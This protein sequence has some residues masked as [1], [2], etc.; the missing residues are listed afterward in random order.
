MREVDSKKKR[1]EREDS[2]SKGRLLEWMRAYGISERTREIR[3]VEEHIERMGG[4]REERERMK[5]TFKFTFRKTTPQ[6]REQAERI[7]MIGE[8]RKKE[9][10]VLFQQEIGKKSKLAEGQK[11]RGGIPTTS[12]ERTTEGK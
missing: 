6:T 8:E 1:N 11:I 3:G 7:V 12:T 5:G 4:S 9:R 10:E 2:E